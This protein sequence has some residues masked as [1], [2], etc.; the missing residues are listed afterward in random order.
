MID[1]ITLQTRIELLPAEIGRVEEE[2]IYL[3]RELEVVSGEYN[4][5]VSKERL[6][7]QAIDPKATVTTLNDKIVER[8]EPT[9]LKVIEAKTNLEIK[10]KEM[11]QKEREFQGDKALLRYKET[12]IRNLG[13]GL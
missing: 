12:E 1:V 5:L 9:R 8:C 10:I 4:L 6:K 2:G 7:E 11:N 13:T 3:R